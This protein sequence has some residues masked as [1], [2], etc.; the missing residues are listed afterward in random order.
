VLIDSAD[1]SKAR[2]VQCH[3]LEAIPP[4]LETENMQ[5]LGHIGFVRGSTVV[6]TFD[7]TCTEI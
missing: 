5:P 6:G 4:T 3:P 7:L 2:Q 1:C